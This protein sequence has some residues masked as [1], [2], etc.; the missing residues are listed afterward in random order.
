MGSFRRNGDEVMPTRVLMTATAGA[1][2]ALVL[3]ACG[4]GVE[5]SAL[6][7]EV[8]VGYVDSETNAATRLGLT[9]LDVRQ[10]TVEELEAAGLKFDPEE[11]ELVPHYVDA[12]FVNTGDATVKRTMRPGLEDGDGNLISATVVL[13]FS[14]GDAPPEGPCPAINDGDLAPGESFEDCTL[15]LVP[16]GVTVARVSF[17]SQPPEGE[18]DFVYWQAE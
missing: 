12:R 6:G 18:P 1:V 13:D 17:L 11:R 16:D 15:F 2:A 3:A 5:A 14:G 10:G 7:E 9:V 8:D 4:G